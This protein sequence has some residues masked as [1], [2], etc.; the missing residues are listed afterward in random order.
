MKLML[1]VFRIFNLSI[2]R[3][4]ADRLS[5][6]ELRAAIR[7]FSSR[8][9]LDLTSQGVIGASIFLSLVF[10]MFSSFIVIKIFSLSLFSSVF[11]F[12]LLFLSLYFYFSTYL[13]RRFKYERSLFAKYSY[14]VLE[15]LYLA[16]IS[17]GS[18]VD[19][20]AFICDGNYPKISGDFKGILL[21]CSS[22][23]PP[24]YLIKRYAFSQP[25]TSLK[26][27]LI[28]MVSSPPSTS[29]KLIRVF[30]SFSSSE[31]RKYFRDYLTKLEI[32]CLIIIMLGLLLPISMI[33]LSSLFLVS[34]SALLLVLVPIQFFIL[35]LLSYFFMKQPIKPLG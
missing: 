32:Y 24:E 14:F 28:A 17:T 31:I 29:K 35:M 1:K 19:A 5:S 23:S 7:Y 27:G 3:S 18:L 16:L 21:Q 33:F 11:I 10:T 8:Y 15:E 26:E 30:S 12:L 22:G 13:N 2:P 6:D 34:S 25:S 9:N 20:I 4:I